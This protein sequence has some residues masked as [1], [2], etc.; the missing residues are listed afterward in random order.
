M[1]TFL[2][3]ERVVGKITLNKRIWRHAEGKADLLSSIGPWLMRVETA[4]VS[5]I[6]QKLASN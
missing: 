4:L 3:E 1:I 6:G 2:I 5:I